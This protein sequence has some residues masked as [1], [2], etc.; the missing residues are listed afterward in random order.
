MFFFTYV[1]DPV[2]VGTDPGED[3]GLLVVV[4]AHAGAKTNHAVHIPGA[5]GILAVQ[6]SARISLKSK[7]GVCL[8]L[9]LRLYICLGHTKKSDSRCSW[10]A[11]RLL[12]HRPCWW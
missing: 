1:V 10:P 9:Q 8:R 7:R 6:G 11:G 3:R 5:I 2:D 4:A 12:R